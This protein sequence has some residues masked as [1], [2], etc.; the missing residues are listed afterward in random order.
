[1]RIIGMYTLLTL[2]ISCTPQKEDFEESFFFPYF[3]AVQDE[4]L[5]YVYQ[6]SL[7]PMFEVFERVFTTEDTINGKTIWLE[8][9]NSAFRLLETYQFSYDRD[10]KVNNHTVSNGKL[11]ISS[12]IR[13]SI[14]FP[15]F[16]DTAHFSSTFP[17]MTD[18][19]VFHLDSKKSLQKEKG[20][21]TWNDKRLE[22][23]QVTDSI[24]YY[25]VDLR[26]KKE[27]VTETIG[28]T[29]YAKG[30]GKVHIKSANGKVN[31]RLTRILTEE[32]WKF[33]I[34]KE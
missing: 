4:P 10:L 1:M 11:Y 27:K 26:N 32:E 21:F 17:S 31:L 15:F 12:E 29:T 13:D 18:S 9:Y 16:G 23:V 20:N 33:I 8:R 3:Y 14:F 2:V 30:M 25:A 6:D 22:T 34:T 7:N 5:I 24:K 19:I 28:V